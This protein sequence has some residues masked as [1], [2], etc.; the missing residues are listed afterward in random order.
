MG[1]PRLAPWIRKTF[2]KCWNH[3]IG[4]QAQSKGKKPFTLYVDGV[5]ID[6]NG[7]LHLAAQEVFNYGDCKR[8]MNPYDKMTYEDRIKAVYFVFFKKLLLV[9]SISIP[10]KVLYIAIDGPA[11]LAKQ[12]QQR[13]R[14]FVSADSAS[15]IGFDTTIITPGT[16]FMFEL[17]K[18]MHY[19]IRKEMMP[20]G[21]WRNIVVYFSPPTV[22]GEGEHKIMD[23]IRKEVAEG[24]LIGSR[25]MFGPDGDLL[26]L[27]LAT[28]VPRMHLLRMD[29]YAPG[30]FDLLDMDI[31]ADGLARVFNTKR[32]RMNLINDF[33]LLGFFVGNDF[34]HKLQMFLYLEDGLNLMVKQYSTMLS[35]GIHLTTDGSI[36][37]RT[38]LLH[39]V[40]QMAQRELWFIQDQAVY[41]HT[42]P[43]FV[44]YTLLGAMVYSTVAQDGSRVDPALVPETRKDG[45][46]NFPAYR[47]AYY[48][49]SG[50]TDSGEIYTPSA[51]VKKMCLNYLTS[52]CWVFNYYIHGIPSW[53]H[54]YDGYYAP[55]MTDLAVVIER[56]TDDEIS[57]ILAPPKGEPSLPFVQLLSVISPK[58]VHLLPEFLHPLMLSPESPL[59]QA[60]YYPDSFEIDYEG[61]TKEHMGVALLPYIDVDEVRR[62]YLEVLEA[63]PEERYTKNTFGSLER[64]R[65]DPA[66]SATYISDYGTIKKMQIRKSLE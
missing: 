43:R 23:H 56:L 27:C 29:Q 60:G 58:S 15:T 53:T 8:K 41:P 17:T 62:C 14:R 59:V 1:V 48:V 9:T 24:D 7:L 49:K 10:T 63:R 21:K 12:A 54:Y 35:A 33:I 52:F 16:D 18:Y 31:V 64:F 44:D 2:P 66:Y 13:Q 30:Y 28:H 34:L 26:M 42:D 47:Q 45:K 55:L 57:Q 50:I 51:E 38:G 22:P 25:C 19:A 40:K 61:K 5:Y 20:G 36:N 39:L 37:F 6:A 11:P 3:F 65:Y 4:G 32:E 46:L